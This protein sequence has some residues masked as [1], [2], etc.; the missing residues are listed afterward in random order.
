MV[1]IEKELRKT[2]VGLSAVQGLVID[3]V[4]DEWFRSKIVPALVFEIDHEGRENDLEGRGGLVDAQ[5]NI[6]CRA[7]TRAEARALAEAVRTNNTDPGTGL[8][9]YAGAFDAVLDDVVMAAVAK[10]DGSNAHW[11]DANMSFTLLWKEL[12]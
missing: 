8:A 5:A 2:L 7:N 1:E 12:R 6:I 10:G 9:G 4:W 3:R 11:Y